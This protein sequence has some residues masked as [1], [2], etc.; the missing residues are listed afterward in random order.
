MSEVIL[1]AKNVFLSHV[2]RR[3][4]QP[5]PVAFPTEPSALDRLLLRAVWQVEGPEAQV[6]GRYRE[7]RLS[8]AVADLPTGERLV[9]VLKHHEGMRYGDIAAL[10]GIAEGTVKSRINQARKMLRERLEHL[11]D[12]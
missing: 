2:Q 11:A 3:G 12:L 5:P 6:M 1:E 4:A 10:L 8:R 7:Y 9:F